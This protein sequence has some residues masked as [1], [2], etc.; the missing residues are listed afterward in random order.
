[1]TEILSI[2]VYPFVFASSFL[3]FMGMVKG[4]NRYSVVG[5]FFIVVLTLLLLMLRD[6]MS[7]SDAGNYA[8]MFNAQDSFHAVF[9]AYHGNFFFSFTQYLG[10]SLGLKAEYFFIL[11]SIGFYVLTFIGLRLIFDSNK[12]F[13]T[14]LSFFVLTSTFVLLYTNVIRQGLALALIILS[15][16]FFIKNYR[17]SGYA[18]LILAIFS[19]AS[20]IVIATIFI[21]VRF[22]KAPLA[23]WFWLLVLIPLL[24]VVSQFLLGSIASLGGLFNKIESFSNK[25][26]NNTLVYIK[27]A[28]LYASLLLF[29]FFG[30]KRRL[31]TDKNFFFIFK[32]FLM[33]VFVISFTLPVLLLSSRYLYYASAILPI[34]YT[35]IL[36]HRPNILNLTS[37]YYVGLAVA[38]VFGLF[39]YSFQSVRMQLGI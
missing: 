1:M 28:I 36:Y 6:P 26:Y 2:Y 21:F 35:F 23:F 12:L 27:I 31:F 32:V 30:V 7:P 34:L 17:L 3:A 14:A 8:W 29:Y 24:P 39:V 15:I 37:R 20:A 25:D 11:Q 10:N 18:L 38:L 22:F 13:L 16:G 9:G 33:I 4:L 19:H 5:V